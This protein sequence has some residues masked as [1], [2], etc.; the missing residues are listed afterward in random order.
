M[1]ECH[2][3]AFT[4]LHT[5][6]KHGRTLQHLGEVAQH[7]GGFRLQAIILDLQAGL[8]G[9]PLPLHCQLHHSNAELDQRGTIQQATSK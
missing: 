1:R 2:P 9:E 5:H 3:L 4:Q 7:E 8:E 6:L